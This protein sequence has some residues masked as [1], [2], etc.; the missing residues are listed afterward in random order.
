MAQQHEIGKHKTS[1][2]TEDNTTK[3]IYHNTAVVTFNSDEI[4]LNTGGYETPTTKTRMNQTSNQFNL[5]FRVFQKAFDWFVEY[6]GNIIPFEWRTELTLNRKTGNDKTFEYYRDTMHDYQTRF[7]N[8]FFEAIEC[9]QIGED[10]SEERAEYEEVSLMY[11]D[12]AKSQER[13]AK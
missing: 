5:G 3:V 10:W 7:T 8:A 11:Y 12:L 1:I 13:G 6:E 4:I 9:G 2:L